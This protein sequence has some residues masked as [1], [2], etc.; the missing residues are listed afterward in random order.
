MKDKSAAQ[1]AL[2]RYKSA[3]S[4]ADF[5]RTRAAALEK[6]ASDGSKPRIDRLAASHE[7]DRLFEAVTALETLCSGI[8]LLIEKSAEN[9]V[10]YRLLYMRYIEGK[11]WAYIAEQ[12]NYSEHQIY[13]IHNSALAAVKSKIPQYLDGICGYDSTLL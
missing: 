8:K 2:E 4:M 6:F 13:V 10:Q 12:M 11:K 7:C 5:Y 9:A 1:N 3:A